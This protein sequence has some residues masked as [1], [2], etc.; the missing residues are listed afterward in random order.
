MKLFKPPKKFTRLNTITTSN[1][2]AFIEFLRPLSVLSNFTASWLIRVI[3][4][5]K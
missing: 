2:H 4:T 3:Y 1:A 5:S